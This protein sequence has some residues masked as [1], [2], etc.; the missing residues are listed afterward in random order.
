MRISFPALALRARL[1]LSVRGRAETALLLRARAGEREAVQILVARHRERVTNLAFTLLR[2]RAEA[3][4][5]AQEIFLRAFGKLPHFRGESEFSTWLYRLALNFCLERRRIQA[6]RDE[7]LAC[8]D[9]VPT[10]G[11]N[12]ARRVEMREQL[13]CALDALSE[14]L[15]L[16]LIL[17]EW[18]GLSY[19]EIAEVLRL[20]VGTVRSRLHQA[21]QKFQQKW[22]ELEDAW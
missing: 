2:D 15:R 19:E 11:E 21:R 6:R 18:Q 4:D 14:P 1:S 7:L 8:R 12:V 16:A 3:E 22:L 20:P 5:A 13:H 10:S 9:E 17:R